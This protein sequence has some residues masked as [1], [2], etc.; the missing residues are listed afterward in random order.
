LCKFNETSRWQQKM[1]QADHIDVSR[2]LEQL[3]VTLWKRLPVP[4]YVPLCNISSNRRHLNEIERTPIL[5]NMTM[6]LMK[7]MNDVSDTSCKLHEFE[8]KADGMIYSQ[9]SQ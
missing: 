2:P 5:I 7:L 1:S 6:I 9:L 3:P 4:S 8:T